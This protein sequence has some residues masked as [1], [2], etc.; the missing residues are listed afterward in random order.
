MKTVACGIVA[1]KSCLHKLR[2]IL[3]LVLPVLEGQVNVVAQLV[4]HILSDT[5]L[6]D[7]SDLLFAQFVNSSFNEIQI[8]P[9]SGLFVFGMEADNSF[10]NFL[11]AQGLSF[12]VEF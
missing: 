11:I 6:T 10:E 8:V 12:R 3:N 4:D 2:H 5:V 1:W 7:D 9:E